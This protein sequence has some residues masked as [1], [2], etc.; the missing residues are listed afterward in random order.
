MSRM[1]DLI[2]RVLRRRRYV[3]VSPEEWRRTCDYAV[4]GDAVAIVEAEQRRWLLMETE[5]GHA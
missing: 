4:F 3:Q 5:D 2:R 1:R